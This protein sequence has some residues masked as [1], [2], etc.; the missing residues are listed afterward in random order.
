[1]LILLL[2]A[3]TIMNING[4]LYHNKWYLIFPQFHK[5]LYPFSL[6]IA[7]LSFIYIRSVLFY[8]FRFRKYDWLLLVPAL[9]MLINLMPYYLMPYA[10]KKAYLIQYYKDDYFRVQSSNGIL[11]ANLFPFLRAAWS[12]LFIVLNFNLINYFTKHA[13]AKV[14][15]DNATMLQWIK[16]LNFILAI[17]M[18][19]NLF[20]SLLVPI[21]K[22]DFKIPDITIGS[23]AFVICIA[24][25]SRPR[26]LYGLYLPVSL[27]VPENMVNEGSLTKE[28]ELDHSPDS[29]KKG[30]NTELHISI[31][32]AE[33]LNYKM[34]VENYFNI[35]KPFLQTNYKLDNLAADLKIRR[36]I[37]SLFINQEY[38][39]GFR[40]FLNRYRIEYMIANLNKPAWSNLTLEAISEECGFNS[41]TNFI[42]NFKE[43]T[44][45][46]P[47]A[48]IKALNKEQ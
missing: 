22:N 38:N 27:P 4:V 44:G 8:E 5:V 12:F 6:L 1:M 21:L 48:Y 36:Y 25:Y 9:L 28:P 30:N 19:A 35:N 15:E 39:M 10:E 13:K 14:L 42:K 23:L 31:S 3:V 32:S 41:R 29:E 26:I 33:I 11:P 7:P 34:L 47:S 18:V 24:L 45:Q 2:L 16:V 40:E 37:L 43:I 17:L 46:T 20:S